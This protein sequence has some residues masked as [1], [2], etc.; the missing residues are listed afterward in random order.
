MAG[1]RPSEGSSSSRMRGF[2]IRPRA[3]ASICCS[4]PDSRPA[5][6]VQP[7]AQARKALEQRLDLGL[8]VDVACAC[9]APS[10]RLS[11]TLSSGNTCRPSGTSARPLAAMRCAA[12][13]CD[14][15]VVEHDRAVD[16]AQQ[17]ADRA[18]GGGL[19]GAVGAEQRHHLA[20]PHLERHLL[21][22]RRRAVAGAELHGTTG[23]RRASRSRP[24][25]A[26]ARA[27]RRRR[28]RP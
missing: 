15:P 24:L 10:R 27:S 19:A 14:P 23:S 6:L 25:R 2:A 22:H 13:C 7:L 1:A 26:A 9:S 8:E 11:R 4:P 3:I 28:D 16:R 17:P 5:R 12:S 18:H 21:Q 20:R